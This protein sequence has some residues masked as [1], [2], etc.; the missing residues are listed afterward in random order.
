[1]VK[2]IVKCLLGVRRLK[3]IVEIKQI[4]RIER[5]LIKIQMK[6]NKLIKQDKPKEKEPAEYEK[7][8]A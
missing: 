2:I 7:L 4:D 5:D 8:F 6:L 1:M 3:F